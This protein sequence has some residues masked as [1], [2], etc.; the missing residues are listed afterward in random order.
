MTALTAVILALSASA[1]VVA[2][3]YTRA[4]CRRLRAEITRRQEA[5]AWA[6][7]WEAEAVALVQA[8]GD[9]RRQHAALEELYCERTRQLLARSYEI[10]ECNVVWKRNGGK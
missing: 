6:D 10:I 3:A 1:N 4:A 8:L 2:L 9:L 7:R 5:D